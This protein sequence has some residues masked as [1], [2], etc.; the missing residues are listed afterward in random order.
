MKNVEPPNKE[1]LAAMLHHE[2]DED[3]REGDIL[4][5]LFGSYDPY[6]EDL[7]R[8]YATKGLSGK[9]AE[10]AVEIALERWMICSAWPSWNPM[11]RKK[12]TN[13]AWLGLREIRRR[14]IAPTETAVSVA[15]LPRRKLSAA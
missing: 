8:E 9:P 12:E 2:H 6:N 10:H 7:I 11:I 3:W 5:E 4:I 15:P 13:E 14:Q 1:Q